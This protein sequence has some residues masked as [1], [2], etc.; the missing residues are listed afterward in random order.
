MET[1]TTLFILS[2]AGSRESSRNI[3]SRRGIMADDWARQ[4]GPDPRSQ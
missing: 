1:A 3:S 2:G 4:I